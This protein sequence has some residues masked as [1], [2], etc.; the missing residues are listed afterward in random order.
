MGRERHRFMPDMALYFHLAIYLLQSWK[1]TGKVELLLFYFKWF[2]ST[3]YMAIQRKYCIT[4]MCLKY[5]KHLDY[6]RNA[7]QFSG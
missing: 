5:A 7:A 1:E 2:C 6:F 4:S 3:W